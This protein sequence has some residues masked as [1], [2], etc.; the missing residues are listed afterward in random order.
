MFV[1]LMRTDNWF[2]Y[3]CYVFY[4]H[5]LCH[6]ISTD[7]NDWVCYPVIEYVSIDDIM[8]VIN[9][10]C[11]LF[12]CSPHFG[13]YLSSARQQY[14]I[15]K[16]SYLLQ[17]TNYRPISLLPLKPPYYRFVPVLQLSILPIGSEKFVHF[18][19]LILP[20][21]FLSNTF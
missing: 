16:V 8:I 9:L 2:R 12:L 13:P 10:W 14:K 11:Y 15:L 4:K 5:H 21:F 20:G 7:S 17:S 3:R 6:I 18:S 1:P 19:K